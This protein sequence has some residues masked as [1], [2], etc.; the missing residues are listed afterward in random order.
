VAI[1]DR[2]FGDL[3]TLAEL[4]FGNAFASS[5][6]RVGTGGWQVQNS[7]DFLKSNLKEHQTYKVIIQDVNDEMIDI[8]ASLMAGV[9]R[10]LCRIHS[11]LKHKAKQSQKTKGRD[12]PSIPGILTRKKAQQLIDSLLFFVKL[13]LELSELFQQNEKELMHKEDQPA[14]DFFRSVAK[15]FVFRVKDKK[16]NGFY[17]QLAARLQKML[18][19]LN[20]LQ[21]G[22]M[23]L[24]SV[25]NL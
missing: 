5:M 9:S 10:E 21:G 22:F 23:T 3:W 20:D 15:H 12:P 8:N 19:T 2:G 25:V 1:A 11:K 4:K 16:I 6:L 24:S 13:E 7:Y 17:L 14:C 18:D